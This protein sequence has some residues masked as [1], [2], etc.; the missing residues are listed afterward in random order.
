M[1]F[2]EPKGQVLHSGVNNPMRAWGRVA[3]EFLCGKLLGVLVDNWV[4]VRHQ[5]AQVA[6]KAICILL[7]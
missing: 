7:V 4:I 6:K 2:N 5:C 3:V 1:S